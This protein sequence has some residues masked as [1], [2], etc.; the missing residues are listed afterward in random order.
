MDAFLFYA[1]NFVYM[2]SGITAI[3]CMLVPALLVLAGCS[4]PVQDTQGPHDTSTPAVAATLTPVA[5]SQSVP[6]SDLTALPPGETVSFGN[7][8][9]KG[10]ITMTRSYTRD[11]YEWKNTDWGNHFFN[12]TPKEGNTFLF[13]YLR[14]KNNSTGPVLAPAPSQFTVQ[15]N[16]KSY[17]YSSVGDPTLWIQG[18]D[19]KQLDYAVREVRRDGYLNPDS[20]NAVSGYLIFEVPA[21]IDPG[22][23]YLQGTL[24]ATTK[25]MWRL[26]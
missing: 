12:T 14:L 22:T 18:V 24:D 2:R 19:M 9:N 15:Y 16:G 13:V 21:G 4:A 1:G 25:A 3:V 17:R 20:N 5:A 7:S 11:R 26:R 23:A 6:E 10:E 8:A